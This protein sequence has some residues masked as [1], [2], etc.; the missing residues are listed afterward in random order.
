MKIKLTF[1]WCIFIHFN[2]FATTSPI[3]IFSTLNSEV[4]AES[5]PIKSFIDE[6][7]QPLT[8][9]DS[10][11]TYNQFELGFSYD[12]LTFGL[13]S[14]Y[15]YIMEFDNDTAIYTHT[16]KNDLAFEQRFYRYKLKAK[17]ATSHGFFLAYKVN[18][19]DPAI[20]ITPKLSIFSSKHFQD[21]NIDGEVFA[22][23]P[24]GNFLID[25][26]FS[27]D[28]LLKSF[29]PQQRPKGIGLS[30][31]VAFDWQVSEQMKLGFAVKD[32]YYK[33]KYSNAGYTLGYIQDVPFQQSDSGDVFSE[34]TIN[35][36]TSGNNNLKDH[37]LKMPARYFGYLDYI[38]SPTFSAKLSVRTLKKDRFTSLQSRWNFVPNVALVGGYETK[39]KAWLL[40][41]ESQSMG[42]SFQTDSLDLD[43]AFHLRFTTYISISF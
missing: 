15:D 42:M 29:S 18:L 20:T 14:R 11:F 28:R 17:N 36:Q 2:T 39:S 30:L 24:Q 37:T 35:L 4:Y 32:L 38:I 1:F 41:I 8:K 31:D 27:K 12:N 40:G 22:D 19:I 6:F 26:F 25:Y 21:G 5:Q 10:T 33:N 43:K 34:P 13:Q 23:K 16:E 7:D 9:G 3:T